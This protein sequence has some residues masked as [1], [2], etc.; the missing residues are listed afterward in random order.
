MNKENEY[1]QV[2]K[3]IMKVASSLNDEAFTNLYQKFINKNEKNLEIIE[4]LNKAF[5]NKTETIS[6]NKEE[7]QQ[8]LETNAEESSE[9]SN[10]ESPIKNTPK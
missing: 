6:E 5:A 10:K 9:K 3:K 4:L 1:I 8:I 2:I 7:E